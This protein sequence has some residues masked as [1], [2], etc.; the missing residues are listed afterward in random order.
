MMPSSPVIIVFA[1]HW[2]IGWPE[3]P[4]WMCCL[5]LLGF[6]AAGGV[7]FLSATVV[8]YFV[9]VS[10][11]AVARHSVGKRC[12]CQLDAAKLAGDNR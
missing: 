1:I 3:V 5:Y 7:T 2:K 6:V 9:A 8:C 4:F 11:A 12:Q 10:S